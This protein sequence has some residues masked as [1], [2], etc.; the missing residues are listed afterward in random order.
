MAGLPMG[1]FGS[2]AGGF[3]STFFSAMHGQQELQLERQR[4]QMQQQ[5]EQNAK[6]EDDRAM[7]SKTVYDH[8]KEM[9]AVGQDPNAILKALEGP[10]S[11]LERL[12]KSLGR[13]PN[14]IRAQ[15]G[16]TLATPSS[17]EI[18]RGGGGATQPAAPQ[19]TAPQRPQ[20][21]AFDQGAAPAPYIQGDIGGE[22]FQ[23]NGP[24]PQAPA[25]Q[26]TQ[27]EPEV[28]SV[29]DEKIERGFRALRVAES[30]HRAKEL[31]M[32]LGEWLRE[33]SGKDVK[34]LKD[35]D[36]Q[37]VYILDT[38]HKRMELIPFPQ[39][40]QQQS[41][42]EPSS[43][44][45]STLAPKQLK[46]LDRANVGQKQFDF[47]AIMAAYG[48]QAPFVGGSR[49]KTSGNYKRMV[50]ARAVEYWQ[51]QGLSPEDAMAAQAEF[52]AIAHGA[53]KLGDVAANM[54]AA[55]NSAIATAPV[56]KEISKKIP[57]TDYPAVNNLILNWKEHVGDKNVP[58]F[59]VRLE[60]LV[61]NYATA[62]G[63]G[64]SVITD[65][66]AQHAR[67]LLKQGW[68]DGQLDRAVD[69]ML[70]ELHRE[71]GQALRG[72]HVF[73]KGA[74]AE[75]QSNRGGKKDTNEITDDDLD[76]M[77]IEELRELRKRGQ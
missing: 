48:S 76:N 18:E 12:T 10:I 53:V 24:A 46:E 50:Q 74:M 34:T 42:P 11:A 57:R 38:A 56:V 54:T 68:S 27:P 64:N 16:M 30:P 59:F 62:L 44:G 36:G 8:A 7:L 65:S 22:G 28:S 72:I 69:T 47:E 32:K 26:P 17:V 21:S 3:A 29:L 41:Q 66:R 39:G 2:A 19:Q 63:R 6:A 67:D 20:Q 55:V 1:G 75:A 60:T 25:Q 61:M 77:S 35:P 5:R 33:R 45:L 9:R 71:S 14:L 49:D 40:D 43:Y 23:S 58:E 37:G 52:K 4:L 13:D 70:D 51:S 15:I 31:E 73:V